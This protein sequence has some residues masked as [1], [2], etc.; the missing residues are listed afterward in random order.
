M[1]ISQREAD[2]LKIAR[3]QAAIVRT[4]ETVEAFQRKLAADTRLSRFEQ[5]VRR[6][7]SSPLKRPDSR[8]APLSRK[9]DMIFILAV[10][11]LVG[12]TAAL[13]RFKG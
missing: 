8:I 3:A 1:A 12:T 13:Y 11:G 6:A 9:L 5:A 10:L 7:T 2:K 4:G